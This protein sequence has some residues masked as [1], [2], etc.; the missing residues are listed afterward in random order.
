MFKYK[1][2]F[3]SLT[4]PMMIPMVIIVLLAILNPFWFRNNMLS[5]T[6][7]FARKLAIWRDET[8]Y[9]KYYH[10]KAHLFDTLKA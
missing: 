4:A 1:M 10:D 3:W 7:Q 5:W 2:A 8:K 9:V 6:E